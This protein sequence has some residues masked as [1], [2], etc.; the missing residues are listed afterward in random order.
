MFKKMI[1]LLLLLFLLSNIS[2][3]KKKE[4]YL[5]DEVILD[6]NLELGIGILGVESITDLTNLFCCEVLISLK[7]ISLFKEGTK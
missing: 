6:K 3:C 4:K 7:G 5:G 1:C 2:A